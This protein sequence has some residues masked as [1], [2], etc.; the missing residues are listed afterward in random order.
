MCLVLSLF[1]C[2][3]TAVLPSLYSLLLTR[4]FANLC[5]E[6]NFYILQFTSENSVV[7]I[8]DMAVESYTEDYF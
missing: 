4:E 7:E 8:S 1:L 3:T 6:R 2:S 5:R